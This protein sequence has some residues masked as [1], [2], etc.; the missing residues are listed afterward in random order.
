MR[1]KSPLESKLGDWGWISRM[2]KSQD[3]LGKRCRIQPASA[4]AVDSFAAVTNRPLAHSGSVRDV[5]FFATG[6]AFVGVLYDGGCPPGVIQEARLFP[7]LTS[8]IL[9]LEPVGLEQASFL[10]GDK[11]KHMT[12]LEM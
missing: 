10:Q 5:C 12:C 4:I 3:G 6:Q 9:L 8:Y 7:I 2:V 11:W 1:A